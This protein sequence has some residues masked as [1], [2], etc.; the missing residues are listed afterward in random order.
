MVDKS[1]VAT[2]DFNLLIDCG[3]DCHN[4]RLGHAF[5]NSAEGG[6]KFGELSCDA[7]ISEKRPANTVYGPALP[8]R[9]FLTNSRFYGLIHK[10]KHCR[11]RIVVRSI[12]Y[13]E[14]GITDCPVPLHSESGVEYMVNH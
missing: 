6:F 9:I 11:N 8:K 7:D 10:F 4:L 12:P 2:D 5:L 14:I 1:S 3:N 13:A